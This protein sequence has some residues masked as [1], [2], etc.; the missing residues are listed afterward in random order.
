M[1]SMSTDDSTKS[2]TAKLASMFC[3]RVDIVVI[4]TP[5]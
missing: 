1:R 2:I 3:L 4:A 5:F